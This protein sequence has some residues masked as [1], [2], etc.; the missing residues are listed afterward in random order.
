MPKNIDEMLPQEPEA[1]EAN[2]PSGPLTLTLDAK[3][4][5]ALSDAD[6]GAEFAMSGKAK[7]TAVADGQITVEVEDADFEPADTEE[8]KG[9]G[10]DEGAAP[11][12]LASAGA[13]SKY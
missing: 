9:G 2:E 8:S 1:N 5:P 10:F 13:A 11:S 4:Y 6:E 3:D 12:G 7:V